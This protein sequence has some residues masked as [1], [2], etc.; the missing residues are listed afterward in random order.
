MGIG[1]GTNT[2]SKTMREEF[3]DGQ[4]AEIF[5]RDRATCCFSG[6]NLWLLDAPLRPGYQRDWVDHVK[7]AARGGMA[8]KRNGVCAS[9]SFNAKKRHN[10]ADTCYLF[11]EGAPTFFHYQIFGPPS[12]AQ[13]ER[14][15]RLRL[16]VN[17]DWYFNRAIGL[18]LL[19]FDY[20]V[21]KK[22]YGSKPKRTDEYW[23][24]AALAKLSEFRSM[25][26]RD[27]GSGPLCP[28][29]TE[30]QGLWL[31]IGRCA[32]MDELVRSTR[33][34]FAIYERNAEIWHG[35]FDTESYA[36]RKRAFEVAKN[37]PG[38]SGD[39]MECIGD[40]LAR[41]ARERG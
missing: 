29:P 7:P 2:S 12:A 5:R 27:I 18:V 20:R 3:T 41:R 15:E 34:L 10:S 33:P 24:N 31:G 11:S 6:V 4:K 14:L 19:G 38:V 23:F 13:T 35:Y 28:T 36:G 25:G 30:A 9:H 1:I 8:D 39:V 17:A 16:L 21:E 40:D 37:T 22:L 32:G 26:S